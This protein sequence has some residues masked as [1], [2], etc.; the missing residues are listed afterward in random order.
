MGKFYVTTSIAYTNAGPHI[1]YAMEVV[2][3]DVMARYHRQQGASVWFLTGTDEHGTKIARAAQDN[4]KTPQA[5]TDEVSQQF[6]DLTKLLTVSNDQFIRTT[7]ADHKKA[8]QAFWKACEK[9][10]YQAEYEGWYCVGC[11]TFYTD[12]DVPDHVCPIHKKPLEQIKEKNWFFK[13]SNYTNQVKE[14]VASDTLR[15]VPQSRKNEIMALLERGLDDISISRD[16]QQL[17]WGIEVPGDT[18]QVMY[19]WFDA[20]ANYVTALGYPSGDNLAKFWPADMQIIGKDILRHH[21]AI[22]PAMLLSAGLP[23]PTSLYV[24]GFITSD[25]QKMSKSIGNV[26]GPQ[27]IVDKYGVDALRFYLLHEIPAD[28]DGDFTWDRMEAVYNSALANE[29]GNLVQRV[30]VMVTKY[31]GGEVGE[32]PP[33]S[34]DVKPY[35][36]AMV[37]YR[38]DKALDEVW[39]LI[40]GLNQYIE[41]EKP[42]ALA[43]TDTTQL[44]YVLR[45]AVSDLDQISMLLLPFLPTTAGKIQATFASG[46]VHPEVGLLFPKADVVEKTEFK[47]E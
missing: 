38:F 30:A 37:T 2:Q 4:G 1:G 14:L 25:G 46:V 28:G 21:A 7:D 13:L 35:Q 32:V 18:T 22:W 39:Q 23:I 11:E 15:I 20:L 8:A 3:G 26:V 12:I 36:D 27:D 31:F 34:H 44:A 16:K 33:H 45:Q 29:L 6:R 17:R 41:E 40:K 19:V 5:Y 9:D 24:H 42:W 47:V 10:I 43:K